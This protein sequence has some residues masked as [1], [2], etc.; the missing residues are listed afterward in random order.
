MHWKLSQELYC[1]HP[2]LASEKAYMNIGGWMRNY[3]TI[4][5]FCVT[6]LR[7]LSVATAHYGQ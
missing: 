7:F 4:Y 2:Q 1:L 3:G 5:H 6:I